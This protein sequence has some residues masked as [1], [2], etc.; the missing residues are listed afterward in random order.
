MACQSHLSQVNQDFDPLASL[1][2]LNDFKPD[3]ESKVCALSF[4]R[5][6]L[7]PNLFPFR[8]SISIIM[9]VLALFIWLP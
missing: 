1:P 4:Q 3:L 9:P 6:P 5:V 8:D 2:M 7:K